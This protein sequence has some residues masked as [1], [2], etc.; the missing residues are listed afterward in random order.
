MAVTYTKAQKDTAKR[1]GLHLVTVAAAG[2]EVQCPTTE[3]ERD[4]LLNYA[5]RRRAWLKDREGQ[6]PAGE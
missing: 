1:E 4:A 2:L 3:E 6:P 5:R